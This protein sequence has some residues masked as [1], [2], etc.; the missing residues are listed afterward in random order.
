MDQ[1][2]SEYTAHAMD[3][4]TDIHAEESN[5]ATTATALLFQETAMMMMIATVVST[6]D[7]LVV[8]MTTVTMTEITTASVQ[9]ATDQYHVTEPTVTDTIAIFTL[10][11]TVITNQARCAQE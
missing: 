9:Q 6:S 5:I 11:L 3:A 1:A 8:V 10:I 2:A 7:S 4:D